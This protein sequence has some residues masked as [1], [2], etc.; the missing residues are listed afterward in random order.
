[1]LALALIKTKKCHIS[2]PLVKNAF[3]NGKFSLAIENSKN[4]IR[5]LFTVKL[6]TIKS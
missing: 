4:K 1:M 6:Y 3:F 5:D 2:D